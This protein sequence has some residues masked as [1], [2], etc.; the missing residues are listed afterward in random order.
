MTDRVEDLETPL[1]LTLLRDLDTNFFEFDA[2]RELIAVYNNDSSLPTPF[3]NLVLVNTI[4]Q[5]ILWTHFKVEIKLNVF[6]VQNTA[7]TFTTRLA[8]IHVVEQCKKRPTISWSYKL[9]G[10][11]D[12][13]GDQVYDP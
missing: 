10:L 11:V 5:V 13:E 3:F 6:T 4:D 1:D 12:L 8:P 2:E 7:P 9:P